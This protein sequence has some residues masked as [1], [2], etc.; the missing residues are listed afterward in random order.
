MFGLLGLMEAA[1]SPQ[2]TEYRGQIQTIAGHSYD[3]YLKRTADGMSDILFEAEAFF[4][5]NPGLWDAHMK[6]LVLNFEEDL[7]NGELMDT[8]K[9]LR[10]FEKNGEQ[11]KMAEAAKKCQELSAKKADIGKKRKNEHISEK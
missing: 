6:E 5:A 9:A 3:E 4:G 1:K 7:I 8:M 11:Q 2:T 10:A